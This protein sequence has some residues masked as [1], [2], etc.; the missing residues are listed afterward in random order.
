MAQLLSWNGIQQKTPVVVLEV[1]PSAPGQDNLQVTHRLTAPGVA[2][3]KYEL[4]N[5]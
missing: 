1:Q 5:Y 4:G 2:L 3:G